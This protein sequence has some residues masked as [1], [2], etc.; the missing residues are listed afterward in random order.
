M[1]LGFTPIILA[2][3]LFLSI[4]RLAGFQARFYQA[5]CTVRLSLPEGVSCITGIP[6][7]LE[8]RVAMVVPGHCFSLAALALYLKDQVYTDTTYDTRFN[9]AFCMLGTI[10]ITLTQTYQDYSGRP[11]LFQTRVGQWYL[12]PP[13]IRS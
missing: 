13:N 6:R 5:N 3:Y 9:Q 12:W 10:L 8:L 2:I 7:L 1:K 4:L 11:R